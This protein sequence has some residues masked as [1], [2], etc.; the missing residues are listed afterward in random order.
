MFQGK[1]DDRPCDSS[2][3]WSQKKIV[4][5]RSLPQDFLVQVPFSLKM[6]IQEHLLYAPPNH[7]LQ[8]LN[9]IAAD[10]SHAK[11]LGGALHPYVDRLI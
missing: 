7:I 3:K 1:S 8:I 2:R 10:V 11:R 4:L 6:R 9:F 5:Q